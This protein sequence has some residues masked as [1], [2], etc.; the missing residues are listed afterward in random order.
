[1]PED[2]TGTEQTQEEIAQD[3]VS[4]ETSD[5]TTESVEDD[6]T[7][8]TVEGFETSPV[9]D[10]EEETSDDVED[11]TDQQT[12]T[13]PSGQDEQK[14]EEPTAEFYKNEL[15]QRNAHVQNLNIALSQERAKAKDAKAEEEN[16]L[17]ETQL[18]EL[19]TTHKDDPDTMFNIMQYQI[20]RGAKEAGEETLNAA[21]VSRKQAV[22]NQ[23][24][25]KNWGALNDPASPLRQQVDQMKQIAD[26]GDHHMGDMA[27]LGLLI[28]DKLPELHKR[29][30]DLGKQ[31]GLSGKAEGKRK[32]GVKQ[33][34]T[35]PSGKKASAKATSGLSGNA[36]QTAKQMGL[37]KGQMATYAKLIKG[38]KTDQ[39]MEAS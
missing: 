25:S 19:Y 11:D 37:S 17:T 35:A 24:I 4:G 36:L 32:A 23:Y 2:D 3:D 18:R 8:A 14:T 31:E 12:S 16:P 33:S 27:G 30:F 29:T 13:S 1:M 9:T 15:A 5:T 34:T 39:I 28:L 6:D 26:L 20:K 22:A 10:A 38:K 21:E 7:V